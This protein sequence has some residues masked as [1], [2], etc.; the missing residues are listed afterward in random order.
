MGILLSIFHFL[1]QLESSSTPIPTRDIHNQE[2]EAFVTV[3][4]L[5]LSTKK[6]VC[7]EENLPVS[8][9]EVTSVVNTSFK[10]QSHDN[11]T[12]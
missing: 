10:Q 1:I 6:C 7:L 3:S 9:S 4:I 11:V 2:F 5:T 12:R 8:S